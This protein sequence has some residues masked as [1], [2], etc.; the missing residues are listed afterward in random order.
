MS[1]TAVSSAVTLAPPEFARRSI[2][3]DRDGAPE[4]HWLIVVAVPIRGG[5]DEVPRRTVAMMGRKI[6]LLT[7]P[8]KGQQSNVVASVDEPSRACASGPITVRCL[9][10]KGS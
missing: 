2:A 9:A 7:L 3:R 5:Y 6:C 1:F 4:M 10:G 8:T